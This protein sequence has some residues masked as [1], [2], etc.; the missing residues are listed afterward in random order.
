[1]VRV[2]IARTLAE[3]ERLRPVWSRWKTHRDSDLDYCLE[4][5]WKRDLFIRPHVVVLYEGDAPISLLIARIAKGRIGAKIGYAKIPFDGAKILYVSYRGFLGEATSRTAEVAVEAIVD[6]FARNEANAALFSEGD[7]SVINAA[8]RKLN[9]AKASHR[10]TPLQ[11]HSLMSLDGGLDAIY[12]RLSSGLR[13]ELRRKTKKFASTYGGEVAV[14]SINTLAAIEPILPQIERIASKSY[15]RRL[16]V[17]F[18]DTPDQR[19][20]L[21]TCGDHGWLRVFTLNIGEKVCAY[22]IGTLY[23]DRFCSDYLS[24]DDEYQ[25]HSPGTVL[26]AHMLEMLTVEGV[27]DVD[28]GAGG[29]RYKERF[30]DIPVSEQFIRVFASNA[31]GL[32]FRSLYSSSFWI[33]SRLREILSKREGLSR[34]KNFWRRDRT[35]APPKSPA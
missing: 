33:D 25:S 24:F 27:Q 11:A 10:A 12:A 32:Y 17:G 28:F 35:K 1:L 20:R 23:A 13:S 16:G 5:V 18:E 7:D 8:I 29:A 30:G 15:Q 9:P 14:R 21:Q 31:S 26:F 19:R 4:Y 34:V 3:V 6:S 2:E 22:W